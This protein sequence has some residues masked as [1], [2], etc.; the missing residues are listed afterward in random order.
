MKTLAFLKEIK[1][2]DPAGFG[3]ETVALAD[4]VKAGIPVASAFV[5]PSTAYAEFLSGEKI[6]QVL[7]FYDK[8]NPEDLR[9]LLTSVAFPQRLA[10][11]MR[12]FYRKL[13]GPR[14]VVVSIRADGQEEEAKDEEELLSQIKKIWV[15]HL[16]GLCERG[17][18]FYQNPLP[19]LVQEK[20]A[21]YHGGFLYTSSTELEN[22]DFCLVEVTHR[23]GKERFVFEK[24]TGDV[25]KRSVVGL[26]EDPTAKSEL[27]DFPSWAT[28]IER[29]LGGGAYL[30][31]WKRYADEIVFEKI[32][33]IFIP[34]RQAVAIKVWLEIEEGLPELVEGLSGF[35]SQEAAWAVKLAERF[36]KQ[37]VLLLLNNPDLEALERFRAGRFKLG[38]KNLHLVLP[39]VRTLDGMQ[40]IKRF[41]SG[42][43]IRRGP[44]LKFYLRLFYPSNV[45]LLENF[46]EAGIDGVVF[47]EESLTKG[48]LGTKEAVEPDESLLWALKETNRKCRG[49]KMEMLYFGKRARSWVILELIRAGVDGLIIPQPY[50]SEYI[51]A[52]KEAEGERLV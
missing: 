14:D 34:Y 16:L 43:G 17:G 37:Q 26:V 4:L 3:E 41:I 13:S 23:E 10:N 49:Q 11:E 20:I 35:V 18:N 47:D 52:L 9:R 24:G 19:L 33:Q 8:Y 48:M 46:L 5:L 40:E 21:S 6:R 15:Q 44:N 29:I 45:V 42:E 22:A 39:P 30:V 7:S 32:Q 25:I 1:L 2:R 27:S 51:K 36:P 31:S 28:R 50:R 38:L 12:E